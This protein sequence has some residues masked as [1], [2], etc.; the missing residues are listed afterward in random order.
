MVPGIEDKRMLLGKH[1]PV[2]RVLAPSAVPNA[3]AAA[4]ADM[5]LTRCLPFTASTCGTP[6]NCPGWSQLASQ[7]SG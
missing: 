4:Q 3:R 6:T 1:T 7:W 5:A 2:V